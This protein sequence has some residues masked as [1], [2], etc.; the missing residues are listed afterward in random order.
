ML[1]SDGVI[2]DSTG[3]MLDTGKKLWGLFWTPL[4]KALTV[5]TFS[6]KLQNNV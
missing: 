5:S 4:K 6:G 3:A 1:N 2:M